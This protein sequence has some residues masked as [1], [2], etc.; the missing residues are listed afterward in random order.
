M[1]LP[2]DVSFDCKGTQ[3][4][5]FEGQIHL[6]DDLQNAFGGLLFFFLP[7]FH[8]AF[9]RFRNPKQRITAD[10]RRYIV[11]SL[12]T[13]FRSN[14]PVFRKMVQYHERAFAC[15]LKDNSPHLCQEALLANDDLPSCFQGSE[16]DPLPLYSQVHSLDVGVG[17]H[18]AP[19]SPYHLLLTMTLC[20][21]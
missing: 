4:R 16:R 5:L 9:L 8:D 20:C 19:R 12:R 10:V 3:W 2:I 15:F 18:D 13:Y 11:L 7:N 21:Y 14:L 17:I 6:L 1:A